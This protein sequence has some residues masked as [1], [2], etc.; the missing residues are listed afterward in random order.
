MSKFVRLIILLFYLIAFT[1]PCKAFFQERALSSSSPSLSSTGIFTPAEKALIDSGKIFKV[2]NVIQQANNNAS[3]GIV[4]L[5]ANKSGLK[6]VATPLMSWADSLAALQQGKCDILPWATKTEERSKT[7][8]FTRP[9]VRIKRVVISRKEE[10]Y[11]RDLYEVSDK[12]FAML[13]SNYAVTQIRNN[14]PNV[15]F[16]YV[17]TVQEE[18]DYILQDKAYGTIVSLYSAANLFNNEQT[19]ELKVVGVLPPVYDDIASLATQKK[20]QL[21]HD[22]LEKSLIATDPR[23]IEEFMSEGAVVSYDPDIDYQKYW[24]ITFA[25]ILIVSTLIWWNRYLKML[26]A[27]L[28][29]SQIK[30]EQLSITDPLTKVFNRVKMDQ[31]FI[32]EIE[33][34]KRYHSPL[35][36]IMLDIDYFKKIN[37]EHGHTVGDNVLKTIAQLIKSNLRTNDFLGRWGGEE[38]LIICPSTSLD[39]AELVAEKLRLALV[40][41]QIRPLKNISASFGVAQWRDEESQE[42]LISRADSALYRAK[43]G[44]RNQVSL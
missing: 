24:I 26:N 18:L 41:A 16:V 38:F 4:R 21:L 12:V 28:R 23:Q 30:L 22:I 14:H 32:Q 34:C 40:N 31:V 9:Y 35:S 43:D 1:T 44:G 5:I 20:N 6:F 7:M 25:I 11:F 10:P 8:N 33:T 3:I 13:K 39:N 29:E 27:K 37:D 19:R 15:Q 17:D 42:S 2:C 36:I